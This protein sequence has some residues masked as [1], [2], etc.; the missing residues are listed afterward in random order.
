MKK[1]I[2]ARKRRFIATPRLTDKGWF[3]IFICGHWKYMKTKPRSEIEGL[4]QKCK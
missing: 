3:V 1:T 2:P 4:C